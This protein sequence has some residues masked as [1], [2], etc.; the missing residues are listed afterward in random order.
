MSLVSF[1]LRRLG[2]SLRSLLIRRLRVTH[3]G[4]QWHVVLE[5]PWPA[6]STHDKA[7]AKHLAAMSPQRRHRMRGQLSQLLRRHPRARSIFRHL[8]AVEH[9]LR[10]P[11]ASAFAELPASVLRAAQQQLQT[12]VT[13]WT[14]LGLHDLRA[15]LKVALDQR[16]FPATAISQSEVLPMDFGRGL[17][18]QDASVS[19]FIEAERDWFPATEQQRPH[20]E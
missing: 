1:R 16:G 15:T 17:Q 13:D 14:A 19:M 5:P 2:G 6:A 7:V 12:L 8:A 18:V 9:S 10:V 11:G 3:V 4:R 20:A